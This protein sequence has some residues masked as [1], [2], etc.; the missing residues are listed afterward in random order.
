[1]EVPGQYEHFGRPI[2]SSNAKIASFSSNILVMSSLRRP[3]R[4]TMIGT[5]EKEYPWLIKV[6]IY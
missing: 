6:N 4:L 3:K 2:P 5:D 1:M